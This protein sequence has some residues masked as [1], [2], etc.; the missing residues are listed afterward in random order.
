[1]ESKKITDFYPIDFLQWIEIPN[2]DKNAEV[3]FQM[4]SEKI[5]RQDALSFWVFRQRAFDELKHHTFT[6][7]VRAA[8]SFSK[9]EAD[10]INQ[11]SSRNVDLS[12]AQIAYKELQE[13]Y[14]KIIIWQREAL[15]EKAEQERIR[16]KEREVLRIQKQKAL[17]EKFKNDMKAISRSSQKTK[18]INAEKRGQI[19]YQIMQK[20]EELDDF[21]RL[22]HQ[23]ED[24]CEALLSGAHSILGNTEALM[25]QTKGNV[26]Q[27]QA[28]FLEAQHSLSSYANRQNATFEEIGRKTKNKREEQLENLYQERKQL[29]W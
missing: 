10:I 15:E 27:E 2:D 5:S 16:E 4:F 11:A 18:D 21:T 29:E 26:N 13:R 20:E 22:N 12:E 9:N 23:F 3:I 24:N 14:T 25:S 28:L 6:D 8:A 19:N 7:M 17:D 1:M